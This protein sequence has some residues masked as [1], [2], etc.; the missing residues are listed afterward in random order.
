MTISSSVIPQ[1][2]NLADVVRTVEAV[3][4]GATTFNDIAARIDKVDRQGRYYRKAA[5]ILGFIRNYQ[6]QSGLTPLGLQLVNANRTNRNGILLSSVLNSELFRR[7]VSFFENQQ[8]GIAREEITTFMEQ[9]TEAVGITMMP[10]RVSTVLSWLNYLGVLRKRN[11]LFTLAATMPQDAPIMEVPD[12]EPILPAVGDLNEYHNVAD[13][14]GSARSEVIYMRNQ[15]AL[16]RANQAHT[17]LVNLVAG[18]IRNIG[19]LPRYNN[20]ID[21][22]ARINNQTYIFEMKSMH[23]DNARSQVRHGL[24]QLY[25][26]RYLHGNQDAILVLVTESELPRNCSWLQQYLEQDRAVRLIWDGSDE[27]FASS[28]TQTELSF[29][30]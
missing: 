10:R 15:A 5:E 11:D 4:S 6:N 29:L 28:D 23:Q 12:E 20:L 13:R 7:L 22:A 14:L 16:E 24:S 17:N 18:R 25:E 21:L 3:A 2:D 1:A 19:S 9:I 26:Y 8:R 27:L 30:W